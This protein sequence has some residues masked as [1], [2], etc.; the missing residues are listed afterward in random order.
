MSQSHSD[1]STTSPM[2][3]GIVDAA[4]YLPGDPLDIEQ[5][6]PTQ[7]VPDRLV[8]QL[9][10]NG[11]RYFHVNDN[12]SDADLIANALDRLFEQTGVDPA[13]ISFMLHAHTQSYSVPPPPVSLLSELMVRYPMQPKLSFSV[14]HLACASV[15]NALRLAAGLL[16]DDE[17]ATHALVVTADRVFGGA[18]HR[19][20]QNAGI[21]S[22]SGSAILVAKDGL[23]CRFGHFGIKN[24]AELHE[25]PSNVANI[26]AISRSTWLHTKRLFADTEQA[27]G[28]S[29][30][31]Y[32]SILPINADLPYWKLIAKSAGVP[33]ERFFLDNI[34]LRGHGCCADFAVNLVDHG[35]H[36]LK[37]GYPVLICGQSNVGAHA[38]LALL[39]VVEQQVK[40]TANSA[41][42]W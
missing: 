19:V 3:Y 36:Q 1:T 11:C 5:W 14:G 16:A 24:F 27:S 37:S 7:G 41:V 21:Q 10:E 23:R 9:L 4:Y 40:C 18:R 2:T 13:Q 8:K 34:G 20:R 32:G 28:L 30:H 31:D 15:I 26:A 35:W 42:A 12:E 17:T 38:A 22:D 6:G 39:P 25:G 33:E 29:L